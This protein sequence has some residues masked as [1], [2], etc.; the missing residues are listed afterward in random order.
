MS[1][2]FVAAVL[3]AAALLTSSPAAGA[4]AG[5]PTPFSTRVSEPGASVQLRTVDA[6]G[7]ESALF[8]P[9][10]VGPDGRLSGTVPAA[11]TRGVH[12]NADDGYRATR[13]REP[14]PGAPAGTLEVTD[15]PTVPVLENDF[16]SSLGWVKP[17]DEYEFTLRVTNYGASDLN[18][19]TVT[20][21]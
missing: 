11:I 7:Q 21:S 10:T 8:G 4:R 12:V 2:A 18:G 17:G 16:V 5:R 3:F 6:E 15:P 13:G 20:L 9:F 19:A 1:R 14:A